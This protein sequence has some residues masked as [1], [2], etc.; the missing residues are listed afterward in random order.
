MPLV[1][2]FNPT[3][4][5]NTGRGVMPNIRIDT[6]VTRILSILTLMFITAVNISAA[7]GFYKGYSESERLVIAGAYL[8][9]G[10][11][12]GEMGEK[13]KAEAYKNMAEEIFPGIRYQDTEVQTTPRQQTAM[14]SPARPAGK[15][16]AAVQYYFGKM[17]R[18]VFSE[19][20]R[21]LE[22]LLSTRLYLPGYDEGI[23]K[24]EVLKYVQN[25]FNTY[26]L[27]KEDPSAYYKLNRLYIKPEGSAWVTEVDLTEKGISFFNRKFGFIDTRQKF[28]FR[29]YREGW[30]LIAISGE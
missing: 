27:E 23:G 4:Q 16:P 29:E 15:E 28:Y 6:P 22:G 21:D 5:T 7:D 24:E 2:Y 20:I 30:R 12:Y 17:M 19:N 3:E 10:E 13:G 26:Q 14:T 25:V 11:H 1:L 9:V 18:A 8:A